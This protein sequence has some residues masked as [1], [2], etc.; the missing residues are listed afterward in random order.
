MI[1]NILD[2]VPGN[3]RAVIATPHQDENQKHN[4]PVWLIWKTYVVTAERGKG[5]IYGPYLDSVCDTEDS[6]LYHVG[7][8]FESPSYAGTTTQH[9]FV[10]RI[11]CNHRF[12]SSLEDELH[13]LNI[14]PYRYKRVGD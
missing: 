13:K 2:L 9:V 1:T 10:E 6:A 14:E 8:L 3:L 5:L 11:P 7:A 12:A 4:R